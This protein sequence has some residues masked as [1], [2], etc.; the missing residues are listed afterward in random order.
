MLNN[1]NWR[2]YRTANLALM[3]IS[4]VATIALIVWVPADENPAPLIGM[5]SG[6]F[7]ATVLFHFTIFRKPPQMKPDALQMLEDRE[8]RERLAF[9]LSIWAIA[10][11]WVVSWLTWEVSLGG[12]WTLGPLLFLTSILGCAIALP[13][14]WRTMRREGLAIW[15]KQLHDERAQAIKAKADATAMNAALQTALWLGLL[16]QLGIFPLGGAEVGF[17]TAGSCV[18]AHITKTFL[19]ERDDDV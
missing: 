14:M 3:G 15:H 2:L 1:K 5:F 18:L 9:V 8:P 6:G 12:D 10:I 13:V 7:G 17:L 11:A 4:L 16:A 19:L